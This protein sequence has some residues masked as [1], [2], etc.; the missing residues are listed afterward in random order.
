MRT[1]AFLAFLALAAC[2]AAGEPEAP[3]P[4]LSISGEA[5]MGVTGKI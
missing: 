2:G 1:L 3:T 4:G 5:S